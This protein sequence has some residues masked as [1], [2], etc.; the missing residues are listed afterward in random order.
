MVNRI[1][2][3]FLAIGALFTLPAT[4]RAEEGTASGWGATDV[5]VVPEVLRVR[6]ELV[7]K[8]KDVKEA[9]E[10]LKTR[11]ETV[12]EK[13]TTFGATKDS[14]KFNDPSVGTEATRRE[15]MM[16][17]EWRGPPDGVAPQAAKT[18]GPQPIFVST[19]VTA[20]FPLKSD[21]PDEFLVAAHALQEKIRAADL[22]GLKDAGK[23]TPQEEEIAE[24]RGVQPTGQEGGPKP[25]EPIFLFVGRIDESQRT[26]AAA[27]AFQ[28]AKLQAAR[29]ARAVNSDLGDIRDIRESVSPAAATDESDPDSQ[30]YAQA[31][32]Y[33]YYGR[34]DTGA[35]TSEAISPKAGK[36]SLRIGVMVKY[37]LKPASG[38]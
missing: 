11:R 34:Q 37:A 35:D 4:G 18:K 22:G 23:L 2:I 6:I 24:E 3:R 27:D 20:E 29:L 10:K 14:V 12:R 36:V 15:R 13:L 1:A 19:S 31:M 7:T 38:R 17:G 33:G 16:R 26:K 28:K 21:G 32:A 9:V 25:G 30:Y 5:Q 8:G